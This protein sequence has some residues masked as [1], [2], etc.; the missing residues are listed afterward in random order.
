M[1]GSQPN[2]IQ[3]SHPNNQIIPLH[4]SI[5]HMSLSLLISVAEWQSTRYQNGHM[6]LSGGNHDHNFLPVQL[7]IEHAKKK[8]KIL[9]ENGFTRCVPSF[10]CLIPPAIQ[11]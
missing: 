1:L 6:F 9:C 7:V 8:K 2:E 3:E 5:H 11:C 10:H 4:K